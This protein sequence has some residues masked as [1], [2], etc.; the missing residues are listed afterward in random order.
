MKKYN[1][2]V[3]AMVLIISLQSCSNNYKSKKGT[4]SDSS[5]KPSDTIGSTAIP[6]PPA[7]KFNGITDKVNHDEDSTMTHSDSVHHHLVK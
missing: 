6:T 3:I 7:N 5:I 4:P 1:R 2:Y